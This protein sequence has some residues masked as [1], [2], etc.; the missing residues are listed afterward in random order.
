LNNQITYRYA[1]EYM[2]DL[3]KSFSFVFFSLFAFQFL[4]F[5]YQ[6][7]S[8]FN[9]LYVDLGLLVNFNIILVLFFFIGVVD[10]LMNKNRCFWVI[11]Q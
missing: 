9:E 8:F 1:D 7:E 3:N 5:L 6:F 10:F 2:S 4:V 11:C